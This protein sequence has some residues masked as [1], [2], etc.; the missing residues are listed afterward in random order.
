ARETERE[1]AQ[2][3]QLALSA[4]R[5]GDWSWDA[6]TDVLTLRPRAAAIHGLAGE[7]ATTWAQLRERLHPEDREGHRQA[8]EQGLR[9]QEDF[10][11]EYR[12]HPEAGE[13]WISVRGRGL[14]GSD[15]SLHGMTGVV[16]DVTD[17]KRAEIVRGRLAEVV[18]SSDDA[19]VS[20]D[21][22]GVIQTWN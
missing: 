1:T 10:D 14:Y 7:T 21:L 13:V 2:R 15:G 9:D 12:L 11:S 6:R 4:G 5:L 19:I 22:N 3:L 8:V 17:R 20:K 18:E 16:A